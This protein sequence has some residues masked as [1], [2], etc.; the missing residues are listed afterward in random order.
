MNTNT[1]IK[2]LRAQAIAGH[3]LHR[4]DTEQLDPRDGVSVGSCRTDVHQP[5]E[6]RSGV[7]AFEVVMWCL[8]AGLVAVAL[9]GAPSFIQWVLK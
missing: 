5:T 6:F 9:D 2:R 4:V 3:L 1:D 7:T 8:A